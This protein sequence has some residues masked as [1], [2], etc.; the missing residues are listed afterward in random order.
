MSSAP[1]TPQ[2][3]RDKSPSTW[4]PSKLRRK[5]VRAV[6]Q[7]LWRRTRWSELFDAEEKE[8]GKENVTEETKEKVRYIVIEVPSYDQA[9]SG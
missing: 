8:K 4:T 1:A 3:K 9:Y 5:R 6:T 2:A 7:Q